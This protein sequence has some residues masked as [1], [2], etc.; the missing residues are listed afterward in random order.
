[1]DHLGG[2]AA[3]SVVKRAREEEEVLGISQTERESLVPQPGTL[4]THPLIWQ[5][6]GRKPRWCVT[7]AATI[8]QQTEEEVTLRSLRKSVIEYL[9]SRI[10]PRKR[11]FDASKRDKKR[12]PCQYLHVFSLSTLLVESA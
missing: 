1:M 4:T 7:M 9:C 3:R 12:I 10:S 2:Q 5:V 6:W 8:E 11:Y